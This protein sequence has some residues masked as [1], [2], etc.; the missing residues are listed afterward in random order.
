M[1]FSENNPKR[2]GQFYIAMT[3]RCGLSCIMC[4]TTVSKTPV[5]LELT[6]EQ[7]EAIVQNITRFP[8]ETIA[9][10]GGEPL[11][12]AADLG[13]LIP[14]IT[15]K[16]ITANIVTNATLLDAAFLESIRA[17]KDKV[18][19]LLS[20]DGLERENDA[21]RGKGVFKKVMA[22][23]SLLEK[24]GWSFLYTSVLMPENMLRFK[25]FLKFFMKKHKRLH[26]DIQPVIT[27]NEVYYLRN[28]FHLDRHQLKALKNLLTF[29]HENE[30]K[31]KLAR[32]LRVMDR[33]W[34][35]FTNQLITDN[36]CLMG[37]KS[38]N[39]NYRGNLWICGKEIDHPLHLHKLEDAL[40]CDAYL[41]EMKR[42]QKCKSPCLAGLV[43]DKAGQE[44]ARHD[45]SQ[46]RF[47]G[48]LISIFRGGSSATNSKYTFRGS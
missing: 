3:D 36:Y 34:D 29:L 20:L 31:M 10:G 5:E 23:V 25:D 19:F 17:C 27:N 8:V 6:V 32:P 9:F 41:Q 30:R 1:V 38:F 26:I 24:G 40:N 33:Y 18:V 11:S 2:F 42:V 21:I 15:S 4:S 28:G 22:A 44:S 37:T 35:Y 13:R 47:W 12:R 45:S 16:G 43:V 14:L 39:I 7:W 48:K 46:K